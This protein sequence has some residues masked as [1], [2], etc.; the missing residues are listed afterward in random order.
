MNQ[1]RS[2]IFYDGLCIVCSSEINHYRQQRGSDNFDFVDIT[3]TGFSPEAHGLDPR[4]VHR[5][6]HVRDSNGKLHEGVD[7]F[8]TIWSKLPRYQLLARLSKKPLIRS[9]LEIGYRLFVHVRPYLPRRKSD[10]STSPYCEVP[11]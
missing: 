5:V 9:G 1:P 6:M 7:A 2:E 10:C 8:R 4:K 11:K 3:A